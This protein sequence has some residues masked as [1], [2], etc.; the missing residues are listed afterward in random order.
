LNSSPDWAIERQGLDPHPQETTLVVAAVT[1]S[2]EPPQLKSDKPKPI[3][4]TNFCS[5]ET[6]DDSFNS[7][8]SFDTG[9]RSQHF[10]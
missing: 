7:F 4:I 1:L 8:D 10:K 3:P 5:V 6:D 9:R 2:R